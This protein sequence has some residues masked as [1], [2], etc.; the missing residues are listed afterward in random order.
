MTKKP[1]LTG[2]MI[3]KNEQLWVGFAIKSVINHLDRLIIW[4][5]GSTDETVN[6]IR[7]IKSPKI[8]FRL[9]GSVSRQELVDLRNQQIK[10]TTTPWFMLIDGDEVWLKQNLLKLIK[11][12]KKAKPKTIALV[13]RTRNA[14]GDIYY[15]LPESKG[16]YQIGPWQGHLNIRAI[17]N[18]NGLKVIGK[19]PLEAYTFKDKPIQNLTKRLEFVDTW[20]LHLT[21]LKRTSWWHQLN[22]I[23]RLK[24]Y[25]FLGERLKLKPNEIP[26]VLR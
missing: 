3:V 7:S 25:K 13:N 10:L 18:I 9:K 17:R 23:D 12:I 26:E 2:H 15:Y 6:I 19:Y 1:F 14:I 11:A 24:K 4:D 21:H 20:Y 22:V 5:T 8:E 16:H